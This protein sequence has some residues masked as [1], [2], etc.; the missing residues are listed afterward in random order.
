MEGEQNGD[1]ADNDENEKNSEI[2]SEIKK[3]DETM[4]TS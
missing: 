3:N 1:T 4:E 2:N